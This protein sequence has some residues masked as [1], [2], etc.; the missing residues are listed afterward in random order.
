M[1]VLVLGSGG[2]EHALAWKLLFSERIQSLIMV[3]GNPAALAQLQHQF[4]KKSVTAWDES[5]KG[6]ENLSR[7]AVKAKALDVDYVV[8]GPD[9]ALADGAVDIFQREGL[10]TFGPTRA[11]AMLETSKLFAK[12]VM[13]DAKVPTAEFYEATSVDAATKLLQ[14]LNWQQKQW[15][16]KADGLALGK[17][18]EIC[19][20]KLE[21]L[22]GLERLKQYSTT[23]VI[24]ERLFGRELSMLAFCDGETCSMFEA[25]QDYKTLTEDPLSPN[26]GGMGAVTPIPLKDLQFSHKVREKVVLPVLQ[27]MKRRGAPF[28]GILYVGLMIKDGEFWVLEFNARFGDPEAQVLLPG[29]KGDLLDW[30]QASSEGRLH[31]FPQE[32]PTH[33]KKSVFV[34]A[35]ASGY[36]AE[37][38]AGDVIQNLDA[39]I[40]THQGFF[41]GVKKN[42][43]DQWVTAGGRVLGALGT[44]DTMIEARKQAFARIQEIQFS[45]MQVR[46]GIA[47]EW[48]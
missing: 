43:K 47:A 6:T 38:R 26:T 11:A 37:P 36:P 9:N 16:I 27:E 22:K 23:F 40:K 7:L 24:E 33:G 25:T 30:C 8:V 17:G 48:V 41:A 28:R 19:E 39:W 4:P 1:Q 45:G 31:K 34:V 42:E 35:A 21:A 12:R 18:V 13:K 10:K 20:S 29:M 44:G 46:S 14:D 5:L 15:V 2:R 3:P 32:V